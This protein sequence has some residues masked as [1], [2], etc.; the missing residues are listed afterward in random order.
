MTDKN[1]NPCVDAFNFIQLNNEIERL[2]N[3][4]QNIIKAYDAEIFMRTADFHM[5]NCKCL[6]CMIDD[7]RENALE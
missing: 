4:I 1:S 2:R 7:A 5:N 6:R 3:L